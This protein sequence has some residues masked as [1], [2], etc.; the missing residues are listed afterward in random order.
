MHTGSR[1]RHTSPLSQ[2]LIK[3]L[4]QRA[5]LPAAA[6]AQRCSCQ[7]QHARQHQPQRHTKNTHAGD[8]AGGSTASG[9]GDR[10]ARRRG[11]GDGDGA[12]LRERLTLRLTAS[13]SARP[14]LGDAERPRG[15]D[16]DRF[17]ATRAGFRAAVATLEITP[18]DVG[19]DVFCNQTAVGFVSASVSTATAPY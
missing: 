8:T 3:G 18:R 5:A 4:P 17:M 13:F 10:R 2:T 14:R 11:D 12:A 1:S 16:D 19:Q 7:P 9:D 15:L 6:T